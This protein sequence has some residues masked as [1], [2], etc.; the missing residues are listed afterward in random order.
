MSDSPTPDRPKGAPAGAPDSL[1]APASGAATGAVSGAARVAAAAAG[2]GGSTVR[3]RPLVIGNWKMNGETAGNE[4][5]LGALRARLERDL[6][7]RVDV[8]VCPPFPYL[9]QVAELVQG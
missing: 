6:L 4:R 2:G 1:N 7:E 8:A 3:R 5:L 9:A